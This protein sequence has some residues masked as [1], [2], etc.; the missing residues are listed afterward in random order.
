MI[1]RSLL[2][3]S[4][5][6]C[7]KSRYLPTASPIRSQIP[8]LRISLLQDKIAIRYSSSTDAPRDGASSDSPAAEASQSETK[9]R[10]A[11]KKENEIKDKEI[12]DLKV[13]SKLREPPTLSALVISH[14]QF[15]GQISPLSSRLPQPSRTHK[16]RRSICPRLRH[17]PVRPR[18][19][20]KRR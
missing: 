7:A 11:V 20:R 5:A 6:F 16:A 17:L 1:Q 14:I 4:R 10:D 9:E 3:Q 15:V 8:P 19:G 2:R 13:R 12:I 18:S